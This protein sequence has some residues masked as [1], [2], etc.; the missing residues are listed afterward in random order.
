VLRAGGGRPS[1]AEAR[2]LAG[3]VAV[4]SVATVA[5][6]VLG[7]IVSHVPQDRL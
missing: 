5:A 6:L 7:M 2:R 4:T 3:V 1:P